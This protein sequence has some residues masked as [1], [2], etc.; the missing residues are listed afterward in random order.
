MR[1]LLDA[2]LRAFAEV[3]DSSSVS[4]LTDGTGL[5]VGIILAD[6]SHEPARTELE[7]LEQRVDIGVPYTLYLDEEP[8][9]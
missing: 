4:V 9:M 5:R 7:L 6:V 8:G 1:L 3:A 2:K